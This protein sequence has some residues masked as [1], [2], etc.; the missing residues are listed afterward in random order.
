[1]RTYTQ[2]FRIIIV[3]V[4]VVA[5]VVTVV[6]VVVVAAALLGRT[7]VTD[8]NGREREEHQVFRI[9]GPVPR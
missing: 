8:K 3:V 7:L 1:M 4:V 6:V 2:Y 9:I 5:V